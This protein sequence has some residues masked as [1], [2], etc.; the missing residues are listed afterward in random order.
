MANK[1]K[2]GDYVWYVFITRILLT[3]VYCCHGCVFLFDC[4]CQIFWH[5]CNGG[6]LYGWLV[7]GL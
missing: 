4:Y 7:Y 3:N 1:F 5:L 6:I 2:V